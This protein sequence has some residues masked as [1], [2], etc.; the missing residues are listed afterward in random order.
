MGSASLGCA[1]RR[2]FSRGLI[3]GEAYQRAFHIV[4]QT[5]PGAFGRAAP[6]DEHIVKGGPP[7]KG[8]HHARGL[9]QPPFRAIAHHGAPD[10]PGCG[11]AGADQRLIVAPL[12]SLDDD[13]APRA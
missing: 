7:M 13:G 6:G 2:L 11:E 4:K 8:Q 3:G 10:F 1:R 9:P 12:Q 5:R